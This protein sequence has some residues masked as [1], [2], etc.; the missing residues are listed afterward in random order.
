MRLLK[1]DLDQISNRISI[2]PWTPVNLVECAQRSSMAMIPIDLSVPIQR[3]K[4]ENRLLIM[5]RLGLPCLTSNSPSYV[6]VARQA[7]VNATCDGLQ[8]WNEN[9]GRLLED[10]EYAITQIEAGQNYLRENHN[11]TILLEKWDRAIDSVME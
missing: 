3:L 4:P 8:E 1:R 9:F 11:R 6:R 10:R 7:G 5:W 2:V